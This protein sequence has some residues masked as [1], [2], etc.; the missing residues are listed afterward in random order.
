M[1]LTS[2][3]SCDKVM[4]RASKRSIKIENNDDQEKMEEGLFLPQ[5]PFKIPF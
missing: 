1:A 5:C 4:T 3:Q 2:D